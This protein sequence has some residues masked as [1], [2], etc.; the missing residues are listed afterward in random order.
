MARKCLLER[1]PDFLPARRN[2]GRLS[3]PGLGASRRS[4]FISVCDFRVASR[5]TI[6]AIIRLICAPQ[7]DFMQMFTF[8]LADAQQPDSIERIKWSAAPEAIHE[9]PLVGQ[10]L[11]YL[12]FGESLT[13]RQGNPPRLRRSHQRLLQD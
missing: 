8:R 3:H 13:R 6:T 4:G 2:P 7:G 12:A 9:Y 11:D 10:R 5:A 1:A